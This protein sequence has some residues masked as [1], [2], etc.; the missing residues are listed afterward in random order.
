MSISEDY[1]KYLEFVQEYYPKSSMNYSIQSDVFKKIIFTILK[2]IKLWD[3]YDDIDE[4]H[5]EYRNMMQDL[6]MYLIRLLYIL[7][8]NDYFFIDSLMRSMSE[9]VLRI[10]YS[11]LFPRASAESVATLSYR[12]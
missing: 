7:P 1:E 9:N 3:L 8:T 2:T 10:L 4:I 6:K 5:S 11:I 12:M